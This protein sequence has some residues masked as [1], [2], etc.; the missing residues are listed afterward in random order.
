MLMSGTK[1]KMLERTVPDLSGTS[2]KPATGQAIRDTQ[3]DKENNKYNHNAYYH[4]P[5]P[6][7]V[8]TKSKANSTFSAS[9]G[10]K[11]NITNGSY[12]AGNADASSS[13]FRD[14]DH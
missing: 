10:L 7:A 6:D 9:S 4:A 2:Q 14:Y 11:L 13:I 3:I 5:L 12:N 1:T 8:R